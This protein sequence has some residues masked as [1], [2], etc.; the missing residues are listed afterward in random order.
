MGGRVDTL[1]PRPGPSQGPGTR[2]PRR[3]I[4][5]IGWKDFFA[6][7][8]DP[9]RVGSPHNRQH[10]NNGPEDSLKTFCWGP[11]RRGPSPPGVFAVPNAAAWVEGPLY[12]GATRGLLMWIP[13][14]E[15]IHMGSGN[16]GQREGGGHKRA[17]MEKRGERGSGTPSPSSIPAR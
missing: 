9:I 14:C 17:C 7:Y 11:S 1:L 5:E 16:S 2:L 10:K 3:R 13:N 4:Q 15:C 12:P 8:R 6:M